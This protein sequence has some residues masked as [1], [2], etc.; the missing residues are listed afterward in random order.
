MEVL[1]FVLKNHSLYISDVFINI[2]ENGFNPY[3]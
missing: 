3:Q 1:V 2:A